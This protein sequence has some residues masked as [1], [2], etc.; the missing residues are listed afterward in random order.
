MYYF[1]VFGY[2]ILAYIFATICHLHSCSIVEAVGG[3]NTW[4]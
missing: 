4:V 2:A 1:F 3:C